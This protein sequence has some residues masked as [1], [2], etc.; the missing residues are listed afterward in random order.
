MIDSFITLK[1]SYGIL[2]MKSRMKWTLNLLSFG[3]L[4]VGDTIA[5]WAEWNHESFIFDA[6]LQIRD[7][8][9]KKAMKCA[10]SLMRFFSCSSNNDDSHDEGDDDF[11]SVL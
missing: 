4:Q 11:I 3:I 7:K 9:K 5:R 10:A 6:L 1:K 8:L 2:S